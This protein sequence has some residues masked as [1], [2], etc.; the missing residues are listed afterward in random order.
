MTLTQETFKSA[1]LA[2]NE[3]PEFTD[4]TQWRLRVDEGAQTWHYLTTDEEKA[5]W[6][7][8]N[9]DKYHLGLPVDAVKLPPAKSPLAAAHNGFEF[10]RLL[11]TEDGHWGGEY[12]GPM[13]LIPGLVI[14]HYITGVPVH[15][16]TRLELI[17]Y[18]LN[19]AN[20]DD[21]G[22]GIHIEG[23]STVFGT[24]L[25]YVA[26]R[27]LGLGPDHTAMV[28]A[29]TKLHE[30]GG[31]TG[32]PAWGKFWLAALGVYEWEGMNPVPPELWALPNFLPLN[33]GNWWVHTRL[34]YLPMGY[35]YALRLNA[36]L[37]EFT[38][39]LRDELYVCPYEEIDW[40]RQRNNV[41]TA[42]LYTPHTKLM[43]V[44]NEVV[45]Y[46]EYIPLRLNWLR[47]YALKVTIDQ[48]RMEDENSFF[49]DIGPVNKVMNWLVVYYHYGKDS[50]EFRE[51]VKRNAD[52]LWMGPEGM[53][54]NGTN[55]SQLWDASFLAQACV[56]AR[57]AENFSFRKNMNKTLEFI[58]ISQIRHNPADYMASYRQI[59]KGAWPFSTR[60][61][62]Y[63]VSDCTA[64]GIKATIMLQQTPG[65]EQLIDSER[66]RDA[67]DV[68][69]TMQ[70]K[71]NGFASY[72]PIRGPHWLES[73]NPAEVFGNIMTE[74]S[75]P[76]CTTAVLIA[77]ST[78]RKTDP[79]YRKEEI[80]EVSRRA[81]LYIKDVQNEDGSWY[82]AWAIC[83]TY[84]AMFALQ[85]LAS[86]GE[87]YHNS[88][89]SKK[90]CDFLISKQET[91]G[92]WGESYKSCEDHVY[93]HNTKSQ[94]V[95]TAW[96]VMALMEAK[97]PDEEPIRR[98]IKLIM[99]RQQSNGEWLQ[100]SI[101]GVFNKNCM[102]SYPNYK[103]SFSIWALGK[104]AKIYGDK[105]LVE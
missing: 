15:E 96:A 48:I 17:R 102:I 22:W 93:T 89:Y 90:G 71:D 20:T 5:N 104:Y 52:F 53:M 60:D 97:Y 63:T 9:W 91:D 56:E 69:L 46:Y 59:T 67:V 55:G 30:L 34:V 32:A 95:Q 85:S 81:L 58:D 38:K 42:D 50:R 66:L 57:L 76:E 12:G 86:I 62:G 35:I 70:N 40:N 28:K 79:D 11:Q 78:F 14:V 64:E 74:Y 49:L 83:F 36:P 105:T 88:N 98:G 41:C 54:M 25:N 8:T 68:L 21:G 27:I 92:G 45:T 7:Q 39:S 16:P 3:T 1:T 80:E 31:A 65:L 51:H 82:G 103:F 33:P 4:L 23:I 19:R 94:V 13:F 10:Y 99:K 84:A 100:E 6:P 73:L 101:E 26:L 24:A 37:T 43:D 75:Y 47:Q 2:L 87:F 61:Q 18:L 72:E 77:L 29:R 44:L